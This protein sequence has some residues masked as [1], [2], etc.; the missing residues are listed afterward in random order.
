MEY[1]QKV[2]WTGWRSKVLDEIMVIKVG[3]IKYL[4]GVQIVIAMRN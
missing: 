2:F 3:L 4:N 1:F